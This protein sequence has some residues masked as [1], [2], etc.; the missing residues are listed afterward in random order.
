VG[1]RDRLERGP[2]MNMKDEVGLGFA[3]H[4]VQQ[5]LISAYEDNCPF[6]PVQTGR[7]SMKWT[8]ELESPRRGG[9]LTSAEQTIIR[10][11]GKSIERLGGDIERRYEKLQKRLGGL[12]V[13]SLTT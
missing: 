1:L 7:Q 8:S 9:S 5:A 6:R 2:E 3:I 4:W 11:C 10:I 12:S 13:A